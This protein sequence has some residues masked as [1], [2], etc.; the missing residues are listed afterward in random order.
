L[1][2]ATKITMSSNKKPSNRALRSHFSSKSGREYSQGLGKR[3]RFS[4]GSRTDPIILNDVFMGNEREGTP[5]TPWYPKQTPVEDDVDYSISE[6]PGSPS[7]LFY[8]DPSLV[9]EKNGFISSEEPGSL[10]TT[11]YP[12]LPQVDKDLS[13]HNSYGNLGR[14]KAAAATDRPL[15][16]VLGPAIIFQVSSRI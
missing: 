12:F 7:T 8:L 16:S 15:L 10:P 4:S 3:R 9:D 1:P 2:I 6:E 11:F 14:D 5:L 13:D